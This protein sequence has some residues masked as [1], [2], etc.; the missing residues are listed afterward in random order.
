MGSKRSA[1][2]FF[3]LLSVWVVGGALGFACLLSL[4]VFILL[5]STRHGQLPD[6]LPTA[7]LSVI[8]APTATKPMTTITPLA[9][10]GS[11]LEVPPSPPPGVIAKGAHVQIIGTG[12]DG[13][14]LRME[15]GLGGQVRLLGSEA[16]VFRV[17]DGPVELDG[18]TWWYLVGPFDETRH[19]WAVSN[20]LAVV[21]NP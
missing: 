3:R 20:F 14:R 6:E 1:G 16:E 9:S 21:Q 10:P 7:V 8:S 11:S 19:G 5:W 15:P 18:Y 12:G 13:L 17:D 4:S 2:S